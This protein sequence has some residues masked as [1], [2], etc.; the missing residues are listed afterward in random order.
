MGRTDISET[1]SADRD[2]VLSTAS[3]EA[4]DSHWCGRGLGGH[5]QEQHPLSLLGLGMPGW[6]CH[7]GGRSTESVSGQRGGITAQVDGTKAGAEGRVGRQRGGQFTCGVCEPA[8][9][10]VGEVGEC[11]RLR[12]VVVHACNSSILGA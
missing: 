1:A 2:G 11:M 6:H 5:S 12:R 10:H 8:A 7:E 3:V 9:V 4:A